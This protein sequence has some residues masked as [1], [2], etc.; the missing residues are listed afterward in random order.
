M[1]NW[2]E[3]GSGR[4]FHLVERLAD[5]LEESAGLPGLDA[6]PDHPTVG[7]AAGSSARL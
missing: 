2:P 7:V 3:G 5:Q 1:S 4:M 6:L